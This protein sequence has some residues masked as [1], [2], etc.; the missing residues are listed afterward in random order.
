MRRALLTGHTGGF[1]SEILNELLI[2]K[3]NV[4]GISKTKREENHNL[5]SHQIDLS[6]LDKLTEIFN[7]ESS[8]NRHFDLIILNAGVLGVIKPAIEI[9]NSRII[10]VLNINFLANKTIIDNCLNIIVFTYQL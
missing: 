2:N 1:G 6:H 5:V 9:S 8:L 10:E 4:V 7:E 3:W